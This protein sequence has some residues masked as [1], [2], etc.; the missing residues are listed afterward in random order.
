MRKVLGADAGIR[1]KFRATVSRF[2]KKTNYKGYSDETILLLNVTDMET[3]KVVTDHVWFAYTKG[4]E[5]LKL[6]PG[7][8][9][10]F[11]ARIKSYR[12]GYVNRKYKIDESRVD[13]KLSH[14]TRITLKSAKEDRETS[15]PS[16]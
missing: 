5:K 16:G 15:R 4:F 2:G 14:P 1:K 11:E 6:F 7:V 3:F 9:I 8:V 13:F 12:K 10:E